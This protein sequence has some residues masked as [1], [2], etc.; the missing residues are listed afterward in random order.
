M[1]KKVTTRLPRCWSEH[2]KAKDILAEFDIRPREGSRLALKVLVFKDSRTM[3]YNAFH[4]LGQDTLSPQL[5]EGNDVGDV[6]G[7]VNP[8]VVTHE[9]WA[10]DGSLEYAF[11]EVD[12]RYFAVMGLSGADLC[13]EHVVHESV[14]AGFAFAKRVKCDWDGRA[15]A[16]DEEEV[17]YPA[18][19]I[20]TAINNE[21][22]KR[23]LYGADT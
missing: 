16:F 23:G 21:L 1:R 19:A 18:G 11:V 7:F 3:A 8:L 14:H 17:C 13:T 12:K 22:H 2:P 20:A 10:R 5:V 15:L 4:M 9:K 6:R